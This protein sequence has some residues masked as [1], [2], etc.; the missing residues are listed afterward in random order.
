MSNKRRGIV[1]ALIC[2][3]VIM[4]IF[5]T[6][7]IIMLLRYTAHSDDD[8]EVAESEQESSTTEGSHH[9]AVEDIDEWYLVRDRSHIT[10]QY[11]Y[12]DEEW[13]CVAD[14]TVEIDFDP[15]EYDPNDWHSYSWQT[16]Y[17]DGD[18]LLQ[19]TKKTIIKFMTE[20]AGY[21]DWEW[22]DRRVYNSAG[23]QTLQYA[24]N[25]TTEPGHSVR[26]EF[27]VGTFE[28]TPEGCYTFLAYRSDQYDTSY[29]PGGTE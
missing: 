28:D 4:I 1:A 14:E 6:V 15:P 16:S 11:T 22:D 23:V 18:V 2:T 19:M 13:L 5:I 24:C 27:T 8:V 3:L 26:W 12:G 29:V 20:T 17:T 9:E 7:C 10:D 21:A 25:I